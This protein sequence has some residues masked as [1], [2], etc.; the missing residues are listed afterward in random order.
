MST[1][2]KV[3]CGHGRVADEQCQHGKTRGWALVSVGL[4]RVFVTAVREAIRMK[5]MTA[6]LYLDTNTIHA[7][8]DG[9]HIHAGHFLSIT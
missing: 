3:V 2:L 8:G 1:S 5:G 7:C 4:E 6:A 9:C